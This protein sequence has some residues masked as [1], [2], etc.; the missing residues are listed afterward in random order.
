M[1]YL[2]TDNPSQLENHFVRLFKNLQ[3]EYSRE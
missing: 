3:T 2:K 1:I